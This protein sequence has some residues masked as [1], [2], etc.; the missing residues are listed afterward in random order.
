MGASVDTLPDGEALS[1]TYP[2]SE[3]KG[4]KSASG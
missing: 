3:I 4:V 1:G 2:S